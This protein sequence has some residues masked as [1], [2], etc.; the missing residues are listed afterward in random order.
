M[1]ALFTLRNEGSREG[2]AILPR[3]GY[4]LFLSTVDFRLQTAS[5]TPFPAT[6]PRPRA[7]D[8]KHAS[9][10][11]ALSTLT[12]SLAVTSLLS[13]HTKNTGGGGSLLRL[14]KYNSFQSRRGI[15]LPPVTSHQL[16][17][18]FAGPRA[19]PERSRRVKSHLRASFDPFRQLPYTEAI[20]APF[21][22][23]IEALCIR[24]S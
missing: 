16:A 13:T 24:L 6:H 20:P 18:R 9:L 5:L 17:P 12:H 23:R 3:P 7:S 22:S 21:I 14:T 2:P 4:P 11:P 8:C 19:C 1:L 15:S 10:N